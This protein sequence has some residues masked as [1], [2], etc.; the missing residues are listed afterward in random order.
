MI[1]QD[2]NGGPNGVQN[3]FTKP[4]DNNG[5][6]YVT[7]FDVVAG[8]KDIIVDTNATGG[9]TIVPW[10]FG[11]SLPVTLKANETKRFNM[12]DPNQQWVTKYP[13]NDGGSFWKAS[14]PTVSMFTFSVVIKDVDPNGKTENKNFTSKIW[15]H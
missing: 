11:V 1:N 10:N 2:Y 13:G 6:G 12:V 3:K 7:Y 8:P 9:Y 15:K 5:E 4:G 14:K